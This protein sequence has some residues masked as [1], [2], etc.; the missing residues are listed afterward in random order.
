MGNA[1]SAFGSDLR[2]RGCCPWRKYD[3]GD[4]VVKVGQSVAISRSDTGRQW[5]PSIAEFDCN[6]MV[7]SVQRAADE[8]NPDAIRPV[9]MWTR[10]GG[11][12]WSG[13]GT[14]TESGNSW[15]RLAGG[16]CLWLAYLLMYQS[17]SVARC[18]VGRSRNGMDYAWSDGTVDIAP[19]AFSKAEKGTASIVVHRSIIELPDGR[20]LATMYGRFA[21]D[22]SD[23]SIL[24]SSA[25]GGTTWRLLSTIGHSP[26][27]GGDLN[28]P[29]AVRLANGELFCF[30]RSES[31]RPM[32][33]ARSGD[34][35]RTW[36][37][38][39]RMPDA[40]A[41][42]SVDPDLILLSDGMLA[43]SAGRPGC[44]LMLSLDRQGEAWTRP[45]PVFE[46]PTTG[47]TSIRQ[48]APGRLM[49]VHDV[50]P[51]GWAEPQEGQFHEIRVVT[52]AISCKK[53]LRC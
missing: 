12:T 34:D 21:G 32:Y 8:I 31:R 40:Y 45:V 53:G 47:Y 49:F 23:R 26:G 4:V 50:I 5:F 10:D 29:S 6:S 13:P 28:E 19:D 24:V 11:V 9:Y 36:S 20:L 42:L 7:V 2:P 38:P 37:S 43:C 1:S 22:Q 14:W 44:H 35:G 52:I 48:V 39:Q 46:G 17:E 25:D 27:A 3:L 33:W 15:T 16:T 30:V 41:A 51:A 18:R